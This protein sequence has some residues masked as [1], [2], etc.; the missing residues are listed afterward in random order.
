MAALAVGWAILMPIVV[1]LA[2]RLDGIGP[3]P[4]RSTA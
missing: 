1:A 3:V 2:E 4:A